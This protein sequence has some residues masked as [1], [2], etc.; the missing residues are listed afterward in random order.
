[1]TDYVKQYSNPTSKWAREETDRLIGKFDTQA[2]VVDGVVR[3]DSSKRV[4]PTDI[5]D[6]WKHVGKNFDY[7][8][9]V[10]VSEADMT[11]FFEEYRASRAGGPNEEE[12]AEAR[13]AHG[14]G[15]ELVNIIT[16][17]KWRT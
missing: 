6:L 3:W 17:K 9:S 8:K 16:G 10:A 15:V 14:P 12:R 4:P 11:A 2:T 1:M 13:A 7:D 5:L